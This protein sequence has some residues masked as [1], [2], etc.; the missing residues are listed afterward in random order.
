MRIGPPLSGGAA[1]GQAAST[2]HLRTITSATV[3]SRDKH[4]STV[5]SARPAIAGSR[6]LNSLTSAHRVRPVTGDPASVGR[7]FT[8]N[9]DEHPPNSEPAD[10]PP[11]CR[12][13]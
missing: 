12:W 10:Q 8:H 7:P 4:P 9:V 5:Q 1:G 6:R 13:G 11:A 2:A 3:A